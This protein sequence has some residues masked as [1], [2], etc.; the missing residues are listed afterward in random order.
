MKRESL[1][2]FLSEFLWD[3]VGY[4][5]LA[6]VATFSLWVVSAECLYDTYTDWREQTASRMRRPAIDPWERLIE[7]FAGYVDG[8]YSPNPRRHRYDS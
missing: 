5:Y 6:L 7:T 4:F 8:H 1:S 2:E 3:I